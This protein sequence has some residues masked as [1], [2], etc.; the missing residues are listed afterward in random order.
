MKIARTQELLRDLERKPER[1]QL[2][3]TALD[4]MIAGCMDEIHRLAQVGEKH[5]KMQYVAIEYRARLLLE[6]W[7]KRNLN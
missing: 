5:R 2:H 1:I 6:R 3:K 4:E 7:M